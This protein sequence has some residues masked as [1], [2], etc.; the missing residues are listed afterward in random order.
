M[1]RPSVRE[2]LS[3]LLGLDQTSAD[4]YPLL[5]WKVVVR[6]GGLLWL[7]GAVTA[8]AALPSTSPTHFLGRGGWIV[9]AAIFAGAIIVGLYLVLRPQAV[10]PLALLCMGYAA[11]AGLG[12]GHAL[13]GHEARLEL[14]FLLLAAYHASVHPARRVLPLLGWIVFADAASTLIGEPP[15]TE[16]LQMIS[17]VALLVLMSVMT[18]GLAQSHRSRGKQLMRL[19][20]DA[21]QRALTDALTGLA[22]R[23]AFDQELAR[24]VASSARHGR[25]LS[26]AMFDIDRFKSINDH[27]GHDAGDA[28]LIAVANAIT[29][30]VRRA[31]ICFR[32]G[33]DEFVV[34]LPEVLRDGAETLAQRISDAVRRG[35]RT[36]G[37]Q[38]VS[39]GSGTATL[40]VGERPMELVERADARL[41][42][43]KRAGPSS[44][45]KAA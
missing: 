37:D 45:P 5:D 22:N 27:F 17:G 28:A 10:G 12:V 30:E 18:M 20:E 11:T 23:R 14:S 24:Q 25:P 29:E 34:L 4:V 36:P 6:F 9:V 40:R 39:I 13:M 44:Q 2:R 43:V 16:V 8:G 33:G 38:Q 19:R 21:E 41:L 26:L 7:I 1:T 32:W 35:A 31:D 3:R 15:A 42:A